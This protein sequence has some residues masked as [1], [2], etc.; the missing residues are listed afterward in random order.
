MTSSRPAYSQ[1]DIQQILN[2]AI[3]RQASEDLPEHMLS[4]VQLLEIADEMGIPLA[5]LNAAEK[6]WQDRKVMLSSRR[7]FDLY[8]RTRFYKT[9]IR[10]VLVSGCFALPGLIFGWWGAPLWLAAY[11]LYVGLRGA[12]LAL[13]WLDIRQTDGEAYEEAFQNWYRRYQ[14]RYVVN[15]WVGKV[16][17]FL[18][19]APKHS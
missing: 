2:L 7:D 12:S 19:A 3:A 17:K 6:D 14:M 9:S 4:R 10:Y 5:T 13:K 18:G 8:R 1:E 16:S 15:H 11:G